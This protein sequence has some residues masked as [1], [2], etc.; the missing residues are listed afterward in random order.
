MVAATAVS[1]KPG[2]ASAA[3]LQERAEDEQRHDGDHLS[4]ED[5]PVHVDS[6]FP[7]HLA[8]AHDID[9]GRRRAEAEAAAAVARVV[10]A[11]SAAPAYLRDGDDQCPIALDRVA[12]DAAHR[13]RLAHALQKLPGI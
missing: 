6:R 7:A 8:A 3:A 9:A 12:E 10:T 5:D 2:W 13:H 11:A 1:V 4:H